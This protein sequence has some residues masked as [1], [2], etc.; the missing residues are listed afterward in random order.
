MSQMPSQVNS[1]NVFSETGSFALRNLSDYAQLRAQ[2]ELAKAQL[3]LE[4]T[5][6]DS[7]KEQFQQ[8][9]GQRQNEQASALAENEKNRQFQAQQMQQSQQFEAGQNE[10]NRRI[11]EQ[12]LKQQDEQFIKTQ[13]FEIARIKNASRQA[14][15]LATSESERNAIL[16]REAMDLE[17]MNPRMAAAK[18]ALQQAEERFGAGSQEVISAIAN[19]DAARSTITDQLRSS[20]VSPVQKAVL[21]AAHEAST[22]ID[23]AINPASDAELMRSLDREQQRVL[24]YT[25]DPVQKAVVLAQYRRQLTT[26]KVADRVA[27]T[28]G[29][30]QGFEGTQDQVRDYIY[31]SLQLA[32]DPQ[33]K[34]AQKAARE[35]LDR[36]LKTGRIDA[37][38]AREL[39][40]SVAGAMSF[41]QESKDDM[42]LS[43]Y[44]ERLNRSLW[45]EVGN[46][47]QF[48]RSPEE[49][50]ERFLN[51]NVKEL[52]ERATKLRSSIGGLF[53]GKEMMAPGT[54][55]A[56]FV[57]GLTDGNPDNDGPLIAKLEQFKGTS[58]GRKFLSQVQEMTGRINRA[59]AERLRQKLEL[60]NLPV[61]IKRK[62]A[63]NLARLSELDRLTAQSVE[64]MIESTNSELEGL[65]RGSSKKE[66]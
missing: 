17:E 4:K 3:N 16:Q 6:L 61:E 28:I 35:S 43:Q 9:M 8:E 37:Y 19:L 53:A 52:S 26:S 1:P 48:G 46:K 38:Q 23:G 57:S 42:Q 2:N 60:E 34:T 10:L 13:E 12:Q 31:T 51:E 40:S 25:D 15:A 47:L 29:G 30:T 36:L 54:L 44:V 27:S 22:R 21:L 41:S 24:K 56:V 65:V 50:N 5:K 55:S 59:A 49:F 64:G 45:D 62:K 63:D 39:L 14:L 58:E 32:D 18:V 66:K 20:V 33:D 11:Q 7:M